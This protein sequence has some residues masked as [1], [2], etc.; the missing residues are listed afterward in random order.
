MRLAFIHATSAYIPHHEI[1]QANFL[2]AGSH[3]QHVADVLHGAEAELMAEWER[4]QT[5]KTAAKTAA[6]AA[7]AQRGQAATRRRIDQL[8]ADLSP[9][10]IAAC[11][12]ASRGIR[13]ERQVAYER[14]VIL[15]CDF[16]ELTLLPVA[17]AT[18]LIMPFR[19]S[20]GTETVKGELILDDHD[21]LPLLVDEN[22][23][24]E[25]AIT[26]WTCALLGFADATCIE[27]EPSDSPPQRQ[28]TTPGWRRPSSTPRPRAS[29][30]S[31]P[32]RRSWPR[33]LEP[34]GHWIRYSGSFVAGHRRHLNDGH[35]ATQRPATGPVKSG[36]SSSQT[37]RG[38][39]RTPE[40]SPTASKCASDGIRQMNSSSREHSQ[41]SADAFTP[42]R[43][44]AGPT[45]RRSASRNARASST[46]RDKSGHHDIGAY[47]RG[48]N[49]RG[50][51]PGRRAQVG[52]PTPR[53]IDGVGCLCGPLA[54]RH[55]LSGRARCP[56]SYTQ[57]GGG[58]GAGRRGEPR[59]AG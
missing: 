3:W 56:S 16:G 34:V 4:K 18:R 43:P 36:S 22:V 27:M 54:G 42:R 2:T 19:L 37:R 52:R 46:W 58:A 57:H 48:R 11:L 47:S 26:A 30:Q 51:W 50:I 39:D 45:V 17:G 35:T 41:R 10:L 5:A 31:L 40:A 8:P 38:S 32:R 55:R 29:T 6:A 15:Q 1:I 24:D 9:E 20:R 59:V 49:E 28:P 13:L 7:R 23:P 25:H 12:D 21:P 53:H 14:P 44:R 33:H